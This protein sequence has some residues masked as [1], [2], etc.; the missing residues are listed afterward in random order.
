MQSEFTAMK[1]LPNFLHWLT[2]NYVQT[3]P[4]KYVFVEDALKLDEKT[5]TYSIFECA[6][7]Y[8]KIQIPPLPTPP[9]TDELTSVKV[10]ERATHNYKVSLEALKKISQLLPTAPAPLKE[11]LTSII[12]AAMDQII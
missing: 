1:I 7:H 3:G 10:A 5:K 6:Q 9:P 11:Q 12:T 2:K 4:D 8:E